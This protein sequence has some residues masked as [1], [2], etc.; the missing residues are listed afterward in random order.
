MTGGKRGLPPLNCGCKETVF[1]VETFENPDVK[2]GHTAKVTIVSAWRIRE[3][4][5]YYAR[6]LMCLIIDSN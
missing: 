5:H 4:K 2:R 1:Q 3:E 6:G